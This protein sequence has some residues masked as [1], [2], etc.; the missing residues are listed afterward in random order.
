MQQ[1][2]IIEITE[3]AIG[4]NRYAHPVANTPFDALAAF[5]SSDL[6][7]S[8]LVCDDWL[9]G[10]ADVMS[11]AITDYSG[12]G[13]RFLVRAFKDFVVLQ[14]V[15]EEKMQMVVCT[16]CFKL[17]IEFWVEV[18]DSIEIN[19]LTSVFGRTLEV[20]DPKPLVPVKENDLVELIAEWI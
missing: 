18:L 10:I 2:L 13:N 17:I 14:G 1:S 12:I 20:P 9:K 19:G 16:D 6:Q 8:K 7:Y 5:I 15:Y 11:G 4:V 3:L